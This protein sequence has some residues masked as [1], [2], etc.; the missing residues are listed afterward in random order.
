[1]K[2]LSKSKKWISTL[3][4]GL[5]IR[6]RDYLITKFPL[7]EVSADDESGDIKKRVAIDLSTRSYVTEVFYRNKLVLLDSKR[8]DFIHSYK[9]QYD[10]D[11]R[12]L[13]T[14]YED[15]DKLVFNHI[16]VQVNIGL[17]GYETDIQIKP[18]GNKQ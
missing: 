18:K 13:Y 6:L 8:F 17:D 14:I 11:G 1:M 7:I 5:L 10:D 3:Y 16:R 9:V 15:N 2:V 12:R 4:T